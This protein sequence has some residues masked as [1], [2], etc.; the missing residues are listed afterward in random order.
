MFEDGIEYYAAKQYACHVI[1]TEDVDDLFF[2]YGSY[3][4]KR[5]RGKI[6]IMSGFILSATFF[7]TKTQ[8]HKE[9]LFY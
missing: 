8:I 1:I 7:A 9:Y 2:R 5:F 6:F 3:K 4:T